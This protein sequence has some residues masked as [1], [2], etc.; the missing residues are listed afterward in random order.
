M[1]CSTTVDGEY[2][3]TY[4]CRRCGKMANKYDWE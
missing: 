3:R 4:K 2:L 1:T